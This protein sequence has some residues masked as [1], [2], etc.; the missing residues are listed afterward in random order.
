MANLFTQ[1]LAFMQAITTFLCI[2][3]I[4][5]TSTLS[6]SVCTYIFGRLL[7][8]TYKI[9]EAKRNP[10]HTLIAWIRN[11][12]IKDYDSLLPIKQTHS[13]PRNIFNGA[14]STE[15]NIFVKKNI[16]KNKQMKHNSKT[17][18]WNK[19]ALGPCIQNVILHIK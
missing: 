7:I 18:K 1:N 9:Y 12:K 2:N 10:M 16:W 15:E 3:N 14:K 4:I 13:Y 8:K 5:H 19:R 17:S 6:L 11:I